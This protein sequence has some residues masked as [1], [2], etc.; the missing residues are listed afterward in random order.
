MKDW[1]PDS[2]IYQVNL[3]AFAA[4]EPRNPVEAAAEMRNAE[5]GVRNETPL[6]F[7]AENLEYIKALGAN[8]VYLMPPFPMGVEGRKG[9]GSNY[10]IRDFRAIE[11]EYG[12]MEDFVGLVGRVHELGLKLIVDLTPNHTSRDNVWTSI[13]GIHCRNE[14]GSL[15]Y[16]YDWSDTAKLDYTN[17]RTRHEMHAVLSFWLDVCDGDGVDG[18]R[19]DMAHMI[20]DLSFWDDALPEL[21]ARYSGRDLLFL[22]ESYGVEHNR[23]LFA[24][25]MNAAYDDDFYKV[26]F[27]GYAR[28][29]AGQSRIC[30]SKAAF[31][32]PDFTGKAQAFVASGIAGAF[33]QALMDYETGE[34]GDGGPW[35]ARYT[36]NHDEGRGVYRFGEGAVR[37]VSRLL[38]L[39]GHCL[40]FLLCGQEFGAANRP[41]IHDRIKPCDKG[42][43]VCGSDCE[44][45][46]ETLGVEF[47][48][49][50][51]ARGAAARQEWYTFYKTL[52]DLRAA[53]PALRRGTTKL[54]NVG[55]A[56]GKH[57]RTVVGFERHWDDTTIRCAINMGSE[58]R[59]LKHLSGLAGDVLYGSLDGGTLEPFEAIV[60]L[61]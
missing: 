27:Y 2:V 36:D 40:P 20:N 19:F 59:R 34:N 9:V 54:F 23:G 10:S 22:A 11:P 16:D 21:R 49:N 32:N 55:E 5:G 35:V 3:R 57:D 51:F 45:C 24:R 61:V 53:H 28:C 25:G 29:E 42:F 17:P 6:Q 33:E 26:C 52:I 13:E 4:R 12:T 8:V 60:T 15:Y 31:V 48:G 41:T 1:I 38:F 7:L 14:D 58:P 18:F 43:R 50:S 39:S 56:C 30:L 46:G 47:E 44:Q 37:A